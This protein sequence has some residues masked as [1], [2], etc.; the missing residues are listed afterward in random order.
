MYTMVVCNGLRK[1]HPDIHL[2]LNLITWLVRMSISFQLG[3]MRG[4]LGF[5]V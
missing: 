5:R 2:I 4:G 1:C 3:T